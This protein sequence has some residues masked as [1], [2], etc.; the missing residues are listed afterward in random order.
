[1]DCSLPGSSDHGILQARILEFPSPG[2]LPHPGME[3]SSLALQE[4]SLPLSHL[5]SPC[6][7]FCWT[8]KWRRLIKAKLTRP[9]LGTYIVFQVL[10]LELVRRVLVKQGL[11]GVWIGCLVARRDPWNYKVAA[12]RYSKQW[13]VVSLALVQSRKFRFSVLQ[14]CVWDQILSD[15][16]TLVYMPEL[17]LLH[18]DFNLPSGY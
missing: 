5:G 10:W 6:V 3:P 16:L 7:F 18:Y 4:D 2:D 14:A 17:R 12:S 13:L 11:A 15:C 9:Q 1:M 8:I